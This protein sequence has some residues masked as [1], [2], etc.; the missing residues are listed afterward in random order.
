MTTLTQTPTNR[1]KIAQLERALSS[2][3]REVLQSGFFG[4]ASIELNI[5]DGTIQYIR[6]KLER[7]EK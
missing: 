1:T 5:Q 2:T 4:T 6:S 7:I 3:F